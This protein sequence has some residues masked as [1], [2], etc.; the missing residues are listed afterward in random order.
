[1]SLELEVGP[2][3]E[4][5][6]GTM[7]LVEH[8]PLL[9]R[10]LQLRRRAA[11]DRGS[12]LH[13]D[14]PLCHGDWDDETCTVVCPRHGASFDLESGRA[15]SLPA[16]LPARTFPVRVEDGIV[17]SRSTPDGRAVVRCWPTGDPL[18]VVYHDEEWGRPVRDE[19]GVYERLCLEGFQSGL[20]WL[21]ILRKRAGLPG[22]VRRLRP[23]PRRRVRR[24]PTSSGCSATPGSSATAARSRRRSRTPARRSRCATAGE[25][26]QELFWRHAP[27]GASGAAVARRLACR[28]RRSR[29]RSRSACARRASGSSARRPSTPPC[30]HAGS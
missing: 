25:P 7:K 11:R 30:R 5:P 27:G 8:G 28:R 20:S 17:R 24:A 1:M 10:R 13:D 6:P 19:R 22:G 9:D 4:L 3:A 29:R 23:G 12:L 15:L 26:L 16:Y 21:T 14:G 18:Y 2:L